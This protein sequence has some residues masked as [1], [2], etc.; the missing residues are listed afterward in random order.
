MGLAE[1]EILFLKADYAAP[2]ARLKSKEFAA[3][4]KR[5]ENAGLVLKK[6]DRNIR[7]EWDCHP[8]IRSYF[9][10]TFR[11]ENPKA[12]QQAQRVL[13]EYYQSVP[14]KKQPDTL[15]ELEPLYRAMA[16]GC[17][18]GEYQKALYEVYF[19]RI[20]RGN[21]AYSLHKLGAFAQDLTAISSFFPQGWDTPVTHG[22]SQA[23]QA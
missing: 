14:E 2:A 23:D 13:L 11:K 1:K 7:T 19:D 8:L 21:E 15:E 5:L 18:A 4:E 9:G 17:L 12:Y 16:H 3:L 10:Q 6:R 20:H 22:L